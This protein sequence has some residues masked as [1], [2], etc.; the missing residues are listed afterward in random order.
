MGINKLLHNG[1]IEASGG[2]SNW[3]GSTVDSEVQNESLCQKMNLGT[4]SA[5]FPPLTPRPKQC[6]AAGFRHYAGPYFFPSH[7][8]LHSK[9]YLTSV[10]EPINV[11]RCLPGTEGEQSRYVEPRYCMISSIRTLGTELWV[12]QGLY[13]LPSYDLVG[14]YTTCNCCRLQKWTEVFPVP[15]PTTLQSDFAATSIK[16]WGL[17]LPLGS[18]ISYVT[19]FD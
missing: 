18:D 17:S 7:S 10:P 11:L 15:V 12:T 8:L 16:K 19:C 3:G 14:H 5:L 9:I 1:I 13:S 6:C 2:E 4:F